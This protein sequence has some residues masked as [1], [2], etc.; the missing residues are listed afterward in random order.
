MSNAS[1]VAQARNEF[2]ADLKRLKGNASAVTEEM[3]EQGRRLIEKAQ[4]RRAIAANTA[5]TVLNA[6]TALVSEITA[7]VDAALLSEGE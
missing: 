7:A 3:E 5:N 4:K 1:N 2:I 6:N